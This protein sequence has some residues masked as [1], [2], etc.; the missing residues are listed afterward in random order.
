MYLSKS[1]RK[2]LDAKLSQGNR[3]KEKPGTVLHLNPPGT[4]IMDMGYKS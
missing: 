3:V 1:I 2:R 4:P